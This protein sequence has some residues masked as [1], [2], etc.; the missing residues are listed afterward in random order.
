MKIVAFSD[1][2]TLHE[3]VVIPPGDI[4]IFAGDMSLCRTVQEA[5]RFNEFLGTLPHPF[6]VVIAG[7]H[8]HLLEQKGA[9]AHSLFT[10][11]AYLQDQS[12]EIEG[13]T[14][15]GAPWQPIFNARACDAFAL[16]RGK[17]M[18]EKWNLIPDKID[19]LIT[20]TPPL[21]IMDED[22]S[23]GHGC[24]DLLEAVRRIRPKHHIFGHIHN[25]NGL[26]KN[27]ETTFINCNVRGPRGEIR[28]ALSF[29]Y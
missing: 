10:N 19:I 28:P 14:F 4:L 7:N 2:H 11:A 6:K 9:Q 27:G 13:I 29:D 3:S 22:Q 16:P 17:A 5:V 15:Y 12:V 1:S 8:D 18:K 23:I 25:H 20:H 21:G 26:L 24:M